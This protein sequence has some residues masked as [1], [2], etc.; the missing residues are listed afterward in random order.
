MPEKRKG[1]EPRRRTD[2]ELADSGGAGAV[3]KA[4]RAHAAP[5]HPRKQ[6]GRAAPL[7][8]RPWFPFAVLA[9]AVLI[10]YWSPLTDPQ[11]TPHWDAIDVHYSLQRYFADEIKTGS[12]PVWAEYTF[13]G[14]PFLADPQPGQWYPLNWPFFLMGIT[15]KVIQLEIALHCLLAAIGAFLLARRWLASRDIALLV[16]FLYAFSGFFAGHASHV[17]MFQSAAWLPW[18]L[19]G[20]HVAMERGAIRAIAATGLAAGV[21][22]LAGHFQTALYSVLAA[23]LYAVALLTLGRGT[24]KRALAALASIAGGVVAVGAISWLPGSVLVRESVRS[25]VDFSRGTNAPLIPGALATL[26][27]PNALGAVSG[28]Y[29]GPEDITQFYFYAGIAL[30]PLAVAGL[31]APRIRRVALVLLVPALWYAFG[32]AGGFYRVVSK[33]PGLASV[34]APVHAW[35][36]A[37]LALALLA[38]AGATVLEKRWPGKWLIPGLLLFCFA[39]A[40]YWNSIANPLPWAR[41]SFRELYGNPQDS[42]YGTILQHLTPGTRLY[43]TRD[44]AGAGPLNGAFDVRVPVTYGYNPLELRRY[45]DYAG[46]AASNE[47]LIDALNASLVVIQTTGAVQQ[48]ST[49]LPAFSFPP[50][51]HAVAGARESQAALA[52]LD[53]AQD[54]IVEGGMGG[55]VQSANATAAVEEAGEHRFRLHVETASRSLLRT[56]IPW[57]PGWSARAGATALEVR[58]INHAMLGVVVPAGSADVEIEFNQPYLGL[59]ALLSALGLAAGIALSLRSPWRERSDKSALG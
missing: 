28:A 4:G 52:S 19:L 43:S 1:R 26:F 7:W 5:G 17:G 53:P 9:L 48:R 49:M 35:F 6:D 11:T 14:F 20:L 33:L 3:R 24:W 55:I 22:F 34:R 50:A 47:K 21:M 12:L 23:A 36:V 51:V 45:V 39:D 46:A 44:S 54:A 59:G 30:L 56:S 18:I 27:W 16:G 41:Q 58:P 2:R 25:G 8:T 29:H 10:F 57:F 40:F 37:A 38:G 15:P 31:L 42:F 13:S 32:P